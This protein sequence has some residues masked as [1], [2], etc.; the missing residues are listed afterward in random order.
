MKTIACL[1]MGVMTAGLA[2]AGDS[3]E[4]ILREAANLKAEKL[5]AYL[6]RNPEAEDAERG[7]AELTRAYLELDMH[8]EAM[9]LLLQRYEE[10][11][12]AEDPDLQELLGEV[13]AAYVALSGEQ[14][15]K[16]DGRALIARAR[17][18]LGGHP[19]A[20]RIGGFLDQLEGSL[21]RPGP[22]DT[23]EVAFTSTDG[24]E[25]SLA[26]LEGKVALVH[27]WATWCG[28]CVAEI[29]NV[30][31]TYETHKEKG[32]EILS[33]SLDRNRQ[34]LDAYL[35]RHPAMTWPQAFD[36]DRGEDGFAEAFGITGIP[37][38]FLIGR[39]GRVVATDLRGEALGQAVAELLK[40]D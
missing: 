7:R 26:D 35:A 4:A 31:S 2:Q 18:D 21:N 24:R 37:A 16:A 30:I 29:P 27:F 19:M 25:V 15:R 22:G 34:A 13:V 10:R 17:E 28:P 33:I 3:V 40:A 14:G 9:G 39:D 1:L 8:D 6:V 23:M 38:N 5:A 11:V 32:F 12:K 20:Q 36:R